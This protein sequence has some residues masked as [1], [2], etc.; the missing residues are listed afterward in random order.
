M[1][2]IRKL[3]EMSGGNLMN[4]LALLASWN[5]NYVGMM[6]VEVFIDFGCM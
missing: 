5:L 6:R 1:R 3:N 4:H 2:V